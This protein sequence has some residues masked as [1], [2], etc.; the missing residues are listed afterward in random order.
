MII[1]QEL[2][3][4]AKE[5][6]GDKNAF[7]IAELLDLENFDEKNLKARCCYH[8]EDT[9]SFIYDK[10]HYRFHCFGCGTNVDLIDALMHKGDTYLQACK[11]LFEYAEIKYSFGEE[12]VRTRAQ[13]IYPKETPLMIRQKFIHI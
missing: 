10:K 13:Y 3:K 12:G 8:N 1:E 7:L 6:L 11:K 5:K 2:I 9:A 4:Q